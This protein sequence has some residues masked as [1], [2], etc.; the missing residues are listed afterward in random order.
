MADVPDPGLRVVVLPGDGVGPEVTAA[1]VKALR[2][3][4][5]ATGITLALTT[6]PIGGQAL[7]EAGEPL[8]EA[9]LKACRQ[10]DAVLLG[11]VGGPRWDSLPAEKR[12][13]AGLLALRQGMGLW[14]N[15]RPVKIL[16][17]LAGVSPLRPQLAARGVDMLIVRE[18]SAGLYYGKPSGRWPDGL[19]EMAVDTMSYSSRQIERL[20][21][22]A[23]TLAGTRRRL[24]TSVDKAN[25]LS[26][27]RLWREV[28]ERVAA[29]Q[30]EQAPPVQIEHMYVDACAM[31][32]VAQPWRF[33]VLMTEN[34]FGDILSDLGGG[35]TGSLGV[36]PSASLG[37]GGPGLYEP[38]HGSA[39][40]LAGQDRA[41]PLGSILSA[42][43]LLR[44]SWP[45][46]DG[47]QCTGC[48]SRA[49][50]L[51]EG[52]VGQVLSQGFRTADIASADCVQIVGTSAMGDLVAEAITT[53]RD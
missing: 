45:R 13:E 52:A 28:V 16:P 48:G 9:V 5:E 29:D 42:A 4:C 25:V 35:L 43:M 14:A 40:A 1:G 46:G 49:A 11:A 41:N 26:T 31:A 3:A 51:I 36:L 21:R 53:G 8:P 38:V 20:V 39:P 24:L 27:S 23:L 47:S 37:D 22:L 6:L 7:D 33:D 15:L 17:S 19:G 10:A 30:R 50:D 18:L 12:P 2:A 32:M 44:H 34:T